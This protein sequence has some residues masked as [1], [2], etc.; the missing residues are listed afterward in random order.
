MDN[1]PI[2]QVVGY[3]NSGKTML[4]SRLIHYFSKQNMQVGTLKHHGH[5]GEPALVKET[6]SY[7]HLQ[8]G[9][10]VSAVQGE[11]Q[12]QITFNNIPA[13]PLQKLI[14]YYRAFPIDVLLIEGYKHA[15][16][17]KIVLLQEKHD[18]YLLDELTNIIAV[19][20]NK[21]ELLTALPHFTF[22]VSEVDFYLPAL[23][24][25]INNLRKC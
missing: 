3:K 2:C 20:S 24:A 11:Q 8:D 23:A 7:K 16:Y 21:K 9:A 14:E 4:M 18:L 6:D 10:T 25:D 17:P 15:A 22:Y 19:G 13:F 1:F 5:G 12:L